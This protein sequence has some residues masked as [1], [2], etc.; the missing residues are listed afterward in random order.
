MDL[1]LLFLYLHADED[2]VLTTNGILSWRASSVFFSAYTSEAS[3]FHFIPV[4]P[5]YYLFINDLVKLTKQ[6]P[7]Q[8]T[9]C[10]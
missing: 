8:R 9:L 1:R 3:N 7:N 4:I 10:F 2:E 5:L 6:P